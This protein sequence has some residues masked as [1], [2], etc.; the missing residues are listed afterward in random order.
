MKIGLITR[1]KEEPY[2]AEFV[3]YYFSQGIDTIYIIDDN[4]NDKRKIYQD[5]VVNETYKVNLFNGTAIDIELS[6]TGSTVVNILFDKHIIKKNSAD[7]LYKKIKGRFDWM[8]YVDVDEFIA[9][10]KFFTKTIRNELETTFKDVSCI[11]IPWV[12]MSCNSIKKNPVSLLDTNVYRWNFDKKH[13]NKET[14]KHKFRCRYQAIECKC[15]FKPAFFHSLAFS[16][17]HPSEPKRN[18]IIVDS[19]VNQVRSLNAFYKNLREKDIE[20][21]YMVCYHYRIISVQQCLHKIKTNVWYKSY[22]IKDLLSSDYPE[23]IDETMRDKRK[24]Y[25]VEAVLSDMISLIKA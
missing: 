9:T 5:I 16:D 21:G 25:M 15:I 7:A 12:L 4:S 18:P 22:T 23:I 6:V 13:A 2:I 20:A 17:H 3:Q 14:E 8:I 19:I 10:K 11:K 1:C 24:R